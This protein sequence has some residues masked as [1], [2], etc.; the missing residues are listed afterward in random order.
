MFVKR[1]VVKFKK[2]FIIIKFGINILKSVLISNIPNENSLRHAKFCTNMM[3]LS[4]VMTS[5]QKLFLADY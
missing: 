5:F 2:K 4:K 1:A 3:T